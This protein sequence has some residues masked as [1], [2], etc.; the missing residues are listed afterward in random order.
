MQSEILNASNSHTG[1]TKKE[2][3]NLLILEGAIR[4]LKFRQAAMII[5]RITTV[6][7]KSYLETSV[8]VF[9]RG[10]NFV[11][12]SFLAMLAVI[13]TAVVQS[14]D[15]WNDRLEQL[16]SIGLVIGLAIPAGYIYLNI[17][18]RIRHQRLHQKIETKWKEL[19]LV[20]ST[21]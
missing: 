18:K 10:R 20:K 21:D 12:G 2:E 14:L 5:H 3:L 19:I 15:N 6:D 7:D 8:N 17:E 9:A 1:G 16:S 4:E 11:L 13:F